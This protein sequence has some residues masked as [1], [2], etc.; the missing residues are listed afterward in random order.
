MQI[1]SNGGS[2]HEMS[3]PVFGGLGGGRGGGGGGWG[4]GEGGIKKKK[5][6]PIYRLLK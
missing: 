6:S 1:V 4:G 5:K 2:M 3:N